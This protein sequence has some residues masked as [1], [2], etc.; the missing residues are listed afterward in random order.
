ME[1]VSDKRR[2]IRGL[3]SGLRPE[4]KPNGSWSYPCSMDV[5]DAA[6]LHTNAHYMDVYRQ[7]VAN[8]TVNLLD[9]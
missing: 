2:T 5:L 1:F 7:T 8:F 4:K 6:S 3:M 9:M